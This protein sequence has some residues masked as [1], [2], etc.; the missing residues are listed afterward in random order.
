MTEA[1]LGPF[2]RRHVGR[3]SANRYAAIVKHMFNTGIE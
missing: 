1:T 3:S 2:S